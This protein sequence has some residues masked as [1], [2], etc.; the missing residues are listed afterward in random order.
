M[1]N[2]AIV[3][4]I[5]VS[6]FFVALAGGG[7]SG[8]SAG[9]TV[10][11]IAGPGLDPMISLLEVRLSEEDR[12]RLV[13]RRELDRVLLEHRLTAAGLVD[14]QAVAATGRLLR[15]DA[16]VLLSLE[17]GAQPLRQT[18]GR[19]V[20]VRVAETAHGL[21]LWEGYEALEAAQAEA[22]AARI[23]QRVQDA[24]EK[25][26]R[27][28][29]DA[30]PV[31]IVDIHRVELD[32]RYEMLA[33]TLPKLL[34]ARLGGEP[35]ILVLEREDLGLLL[36][37]KQLTEGEDSAFWDSGI[38]I[39]GRLQRSDGRLEMTLRW[40]RAAGEGSIV[41]SVDPNAPARAVDAA[42]AELLKAAI[43]TSSSARWDPQKEA[44]E[45]FRQGM[46]L[47]AHSRQENAFA[48]LE[49]AYALQPETTAYV[50]ALFE[51]EW[52]LRGYAFASY[53]VNPTNLTHYTDEQLAELVS[54]LVRSVRRDWE[55]GALSA[56]D[57]LDERNRPAWIRSGQWSYFAH[58]ASV[59]SPEVRAMN[60]ENR[61]I[62]CEVTEQAMKSKPPEKRLRIGDLDGRAALP[63]ISSDDP[64]EVMAEVRRVYDELILPPAQGG[65]ISSSDVRS[66]ACERCLLTGSWGPSAW[67]LR[68]SHFCDCEAQI[69]TL[70]LAYIEE[71]SRFED[72]IVRFFAHAAMAEGAS[73]DAP[74]PSQTIMEFWWKAVKIL[75][76]ELHGPSTPLADQTRWRICLPM[77]MIACKAL[78]NDPCEGITTWE[79]VFDPLI[80]SKNIRA[81]V[82][83]DPGSSILAAYA[84]GL[85]V[86]AGERFHNLLSRIE[87]TLAADRDP[88]YA[89]ATLS[90]VRNLRIQFETRY[91]MSTPKSDLSTIEVAM[92]LKRA[93]Q[94][95]QPSRELHRVEWQ[96][97]DEM[98]YLASIELWGL[99]TLARVDLTGRTPACLLKTETSINW[100]NLV[101]WA[102]MDDAGYL[103]L[104]DIGIAVLP[105]EAWNRG[106]DVAVNPKVLTREHGLPSLLI[107]AITQDRG[108]LWIAYGRPDAES[109]L[110]LY[111][112]RT[113]QWESV[114]CSTLK[115]EEPFKA[116]RPYGLMQ[117]AVVPPNSLF[118]TNQ[119]KMFQ[120]MTPWMGLWRLDTT[121]HSVRY[122]GYCGVETGIFGRLEATGKD[123]WCKGNLSLVRIDTE[124]EEASYIFGTTWRASTR[125]AFALAPWLDCRNDLFLPEDFMP[126]VPFGS[127]ERGGID[128]TSSAMHG[129]DLWTLL[130]NTQIAV[131]HRGRPF[132]EATILANDLLD[133]GPVLKFL[134]TPYGLV[135]IGDGA[136]GLVKTA[137]PSQARSR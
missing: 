8:N 62:W 38:L 11:L 24:M 61:R 41:A 108:R 59:S 42:A 103:A 20:R 2:R 107:T 19:L 64:Q 112:P 99:P 110:G 72:P 98:L 7:T 114:L 26:A 32:E 105:K 81:L 95:S 126:A 84:D 129:D 120:G 66:N 132:A 67:A 75:T 123:L 106:Q 31:G 53:R 56:G 85:T 14:R 60:R 89:N 127:R 92:L 134:S 100:T 69:K 115:G 22:A 34:S 137:E 135:A 90:R 119:P 35:R 88:T 29:G 102:V 122:Y 54:L 1:G 5:V 30:V 9:R 83:W 77:K 36:K 47:R 131:I 15:A 86:R 74:V 104:R 87:N 21:R 130:G 58:R 28:D 37:E 45:F 80:E 40:R 101:G 78:V 4:A 124:S 55:S 91:G 117:L 71:L 57:F 50:A 96:L 68:D 93:G 133:G 46:L 65:T 23:A 44:Q 49:T 128:L 33:R 13:E 18:Q 39:D 63:W 111:D 51:N 79:R 6:L 27:L 116:G 48:P 70:W 25:I 52:E 94:P 43:A 136:V 113:G 3:N 16:M 12:L 10:A 17:N 125:K 121:T 97:R 73:R 76:E 109:G 82:S 118:F